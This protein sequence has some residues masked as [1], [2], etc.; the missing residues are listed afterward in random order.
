M[1]VH[2]PREG[3]QQERGFFY[4]GPFA[5]DVSRRRLFRRGLA[6]HVTGKAF[7]LLVLLVRNAG[8][9]LTVDE[10]MGA[11]WGGNEEATEATLR[12]H[13]LMLR[14]ALEDGVTDR[15]IATEYGRGYRFVGDVNQQS[16]RYM[17]DVVEQYCA[18][19]A[20]FRNASSPAALMASL[21]LYERALAI[22]D[23]SAAALAGAA[24]TRAI[25]ADFQYDRPK[26]LLELTQRQSEGALSIDP[27]CLEAVVALC[28]VRLDYHWDFSGAL[29]LAARAL[30]IDPK[31]R[32]AAFMYAWILSL[33]AR[34]ADSVAFLDSL[35]SDVAN[36]NIM[37]TCRAITT[38]FSGDYEAGMAGLEVVCDRWPDY[39]FAQTFLGL[40]LLLFGKTDQALRIFDQVRLSSYDPLVDRQ[41]NARYFAEGYALYARF[42]RGD[43]QNGEKDT[44]RLKRFARSQF[45]PATCFALGEIGRKNGA[46]AL[47]YIRQCADNRE[48]WY[49]HL[50]VE[51]LVKELGL[52][53]AELYRSLDDQ[54]CLSSTG[55]S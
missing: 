18:A 48:C 17:A 37:A 1:K 29:E 47:Q 15:Y 34:F 25:M 9:T 19:G 22:D 46:A 44:Q 26:E 21:H 14:H 43:S 31:H 49:T 2:L 50:G 40:A 24:L 10:I 54:A 8:V 36:M 16:P 13:V 41:M 4:F 45:I 3:D 30:G 38:L 6:L 5:L 33:S 52:K 28:K 27:C 55:N 7:R 35:P 11:V 51:P 20:E 12:Q 32:I 53:P 42:R 23:A 39:W